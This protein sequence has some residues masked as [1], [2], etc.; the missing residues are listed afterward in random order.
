MKNNM[1]INFKQNYHMIQQF[2][3][4]VFNPRKTKF[5]KILIHKYLC[6]LIFIAALFT[7][8][9]NGHC[10]SVPQQMNE[11]RIPVKSFIEFLLCFRHFNQISKQI[12]PDFNNWIIKKN[13]IF[14]FLTT[15]MDLEGSMLCEISLT[16]ERQI[17]YDFTFMF[18]LTNKRTNVTRSK[19]LQIQITNRWLLGGWGRQEIGEEA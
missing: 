5:K 6:I 15:G 4:C 17:L 8:E 3:C 11:L 19:Q 16:R 12:N 10:L 18:S 14:P 13:K 9:K 2:H 1:E 7:T